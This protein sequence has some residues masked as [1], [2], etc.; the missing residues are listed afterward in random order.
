MDFYGLQQAL[1]QCTKYKHAR[2]LSR[3]K[4]PFASWKNK[5]TPIYTQNAENPIWR[6]YVVSTSQCG[7]QR[8]AVVRCARPGTGAWQAPLR[9]QVWRDAKWSLSTIVAERPMASQKTARLHQRLPEA[10]L[11][12]AVQDWV[13]CFQHMVFLPAKEC[14]CRWTTSNL[15]PA[16]EDSGNE[17]P[18]N[19]TLCVALSGGSLWSSHLVCMLSLEQCSMRL[20]EVWTL[21]IVTVDVCENYAKEWP[22]VIVAQNVGSKHFF[23]F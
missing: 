3:K 22:K 10:H 21:A 4:K 6:K 1:R 16:L 7:P 23:Q 9:P 15:F 2:T 12:L 19:P 11:P 8:K 20:D 18:K 5:N 17:N 13:K 14:F